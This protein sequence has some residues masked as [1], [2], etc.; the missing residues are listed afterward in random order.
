MLDD[1]KR[2][3]DNSYDKIFMFF[4][5]EHLYD[6]IPYLKNLNR[7]LAPK[8]AILMVMPNA[9]DVLL[10][11]YNIPKFKDFYFNIAHPFYYSKKTLSLLLKKAGFC[12]FNILP[13]QRYDLSNHMNWMM[14]GKPG[15]QGKYN[16]IFSR[17]VLK[18]YADVLK[19]NFICDTLFCIV[20]KY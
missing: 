18:S 17:Q 10:N 7:I 4:L 16:H 15:G 1:L 3:P 5:L 12:N 2:C 20:R 19:K 9:Y 13:E 8:G 14:E 6:P 11:V